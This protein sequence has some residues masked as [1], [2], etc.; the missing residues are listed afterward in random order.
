MGA[1]IIAQLRHGRT[2]MA[3]AQR[4]FFCDYNGMNT[5]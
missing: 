1:C 2:Q 3:E 4:R 5:A